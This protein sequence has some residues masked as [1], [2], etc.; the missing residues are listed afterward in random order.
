ML[1]LVSLHPKKGIG[2]WTCN[3]KRLLGNGD[4]C[5]VWSWFFL[6]GWF[7]SQVKSYMGVLAVLEFWE[8]KAYS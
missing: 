1:A 7:F 5:G 3:V 8:V 6:F 4:V 2:E